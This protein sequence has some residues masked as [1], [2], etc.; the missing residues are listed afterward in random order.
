MGVVYK[1]RQTSLKRIVA[2]KMIL[3]GAHASAD[4]LARFQREAEAVARLQHAH[5]VQIYDVG[6]HNGLPYFSLEY[7][8]GGSLSAKLHGGTLAP[9]VA[10]GLVETLARAVEHAHQRGILHRDLKPA[11]VLFLA[12]GTPKITDF[13]LA[14]DLGGGTA[15]TASGALVGTPSYMAPEQAATHH[16]HPLGPATDV[17]ALGAILYECLT[18]RPPFR[19]DSHLDTVLRVISEE[20]TPPRQLRPE[21][22]PALDAVC[23][24]CLQKDPARRYPSALALAEELRRFQDRLP[25]GEASEGGR[26]GRAT[27]PGSPSLQPIPTLRPRGD[28]TLVTR[29]ARPRPPSTTE[30][31]ATGLETYLSQLRL[32]LEELSCDFCRFEHVVTDGQAPEG[33]S[34]DREYDLGQP[35][36]YA[37]IRVAVPGR[38]P[39]FV[40]IK[41]GYAGSRLL[42]TFR[43]KYGRQTPALAEASKVVLVI[44]REPRSDWPSL[45]AELTRCLPPSL[46]LE[47]WDEA[48]LRTLLRERFGADIPAITE[49]GLGEA[50]QAIDRAKGFHAF[51]AGDFVDYTSDPLQAQLLWHFGFWRLR[52][53][54]DALGMTPRDV[55]PPGLYRGV[56]V[57]SADLCAYSDYVRDTRDEAVIRDNLTAFYS[58]ARYQIINRGGMLYQ[59]LEDEVLALFGVPDQRPGYIQDALDTARALRSI[60]RSVSNHWQRHID[61][62]QPAAGLHIGMA[63]GDLQVVSLRPFSRMHLGVVGDPLKVAQR[64]LPGAGPDQIAVSNSFYQAL[65]ENEKD[66]FREMQS[67]EDRSLGRIR[68]WK[69][70][71]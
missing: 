25:G 36:A 45:E 28:E 12:D 68:A 2:L 44:D 41:Y 19:A 48:R 23:V 67:T 70:G 10:A 65:P 8:D 43:R 62:I 38:A 59:F 20:V 50:R 26:R 9:R 58:K 4:M 6:E 15:L 24:K 3:V 71:G 27:D 35:G 13:G 53:L 49:D 22:P 52:Q 51:G 16:A 69:S 30:L 64:L 34:I 60:G 21:I 5:I 11:N 18:G 7:C 32:L 46:A 61:R 55:L 47:V 63:L 37:D 1:A 31:R 33:I 57:L 66:A 42:E 40:E 39:Y 54:R 17:Y 56:V 14:K 29:P